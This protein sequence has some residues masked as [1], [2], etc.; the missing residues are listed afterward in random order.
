VRKLSILIALGAIVLSS[1]LV[2]PR[3][4][5]ADERFDAAAKAYAAQKYDDAVAR[6]EALRQSGIH[7]PSLFYDL[8]NAHFRAGNLGPAILNYERALRLEPDADDVRYNLQVARETVSARHGKDTVAGAEREPLWIR[9]GQ[10]LPLPTLAWGFLALDLLFFG[11]LVAVRF[12][13]TGFLRTGLIV[14]DVFLGLAG[15]FVGLLLAA[16]LHLVHNVRLSVVVSDEVVMRE[17]P[18]A[19]RREMPKLHAG[20]RV[21]ILRE[22]QGWYRV[23]LANRMEGWVP[24]AA[25]EAI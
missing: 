10:L 11:V 18:D 21:E 7:H 9:A 5:H 22:S 1:V 15:A 23:R 4:A 24:K 8:G 2:A 16:Q 13:P 14:G 17:G 19:T 25:V 6:F 20:H 3:A 12:L